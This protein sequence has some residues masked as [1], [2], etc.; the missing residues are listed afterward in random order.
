MMLLKCKLC[1]RMEISENKKNSRSL[2]NDI[3]KNMKA[4]EKKTCC[5]DEFKNLLHDH[6]DTRWKFTI[7]EI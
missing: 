7:K 5:L 6:F 2:C 1:G 3:Q 4:T